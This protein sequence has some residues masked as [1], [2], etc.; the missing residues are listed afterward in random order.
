MP[1]RS[2]AGIVAYGIDHGG[3]DVG[4]GDPELAHVEHVAFG[5]CSKPLATFAEGLAVGRFVGHEGPCAAARDDDPVTFEFAV[6]AGDGARSQAHLA[7]EVAHGGEAVGRVQAPDRDH[8][9][10]LGAELFE[11]GHTAS[12]VEPDDQPAGDAGTIGVFD[13]GVEVGLGIA[14]VRIVLIQTTQSVN[15]VP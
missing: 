1:A 5:R 8:D 11:A 10:E 6:R 4:L 9:R 7:S 2:G 12:G 13:D 14:H 15:Q 3:G